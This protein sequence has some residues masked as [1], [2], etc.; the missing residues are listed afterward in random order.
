VAKTIK[1]DYLT[2]LWI[3]WISDRK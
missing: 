3:F 1:K 2:H